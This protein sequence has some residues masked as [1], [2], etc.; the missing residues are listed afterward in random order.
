MNK[1]ILLVADFA[2]FGGTKTF[3]RNILEFYFKN[4]SK[5]TVLLSRSQLD[6]EIFGILKKYNY[7]Y[8]IVERSNSLFLQLFPISTIYDLFIYYQYLKQNLFDSITISSSVPG[9][10]FGI[11]LLH[12]KVI[13]FLHT[14]PAKSKNPL[15]FLEN[16]YIK[17]LLSKTHVISTVSRYSLEMIIS[18]WKLKNF[19]QFLHYSHLGVN[20]DIHTS[21]KSI[22]TQNN[23]TVNIVTFG[24]LEKYKNPQLWLDAAIDITHDYNNV[25][26]TWIG[27]GS[28]QSFLLDRLSKLHQP[29]INIV[30]F[31][32]NPEAFLRTADIYLQPSDYESFGISVVEAMLHGLPCIVSNNG[33]LPELVDRTSGLVLPNLSLFDLKRSLALLIEDEALRIKLGKAGKQKALNL[34]TLEKWENN[35]KNLHNKL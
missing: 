19:T 26:F 33:S 22:S 35:M 23:K 4:N 20:V 7:S 10:Y 18:Y 25:Y 17:L 34:F 29:R 28:M 31:Q 27:E 6:K 32:N 13:Y 3:V 14:P 1:N 12:K 2:A 11:L 8:H 24:H 5:V 15:H 16:W 9:K 30:P 21:S